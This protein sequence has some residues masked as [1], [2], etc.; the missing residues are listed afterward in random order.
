MEEIENYRI[1]VWPAALIKLNLPHIVI[2]SSVLS[3]LSTDKEL[4]FNF[5]FPEVSLFFAQIQTHKG[6]EGERG[7]CPS[8]VR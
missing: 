8:Y 3:Y 5:F 4:I 7:R 1:T 2:M 6:L